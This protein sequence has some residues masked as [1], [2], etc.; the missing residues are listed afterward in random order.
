VVRNDNIPRANAKIMFV[1]STQT[2]AQQTVTADTAGRFQANLAA[3]S[4]NVYL[5]GSDGN[6]TFYTRIDV[7]ETQ[8]GRITLVN[9]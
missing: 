4:W 7:N 8:P 1:S 2:Q 3:G 9:R 5:Q 6:P